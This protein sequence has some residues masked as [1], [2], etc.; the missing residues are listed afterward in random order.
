MGSDSSFNT[1]S[2]SELCGRVLL[3]DDD[4][5]MLTLL[6]RHLSHLN[7][8]NDKEE[9][10]VVDD[11]PLLVRINGRLLS[12]LGYK[13]TES[14]SSQE[15]LERVRSEPDRF[16]LLITDQT[17]PQL[18]GAE[19]AAEVLN[20]APNILVIMCTGHSNVVSKEKALAMGICRY[21]FKPV[22]GMELVEAVREVLDE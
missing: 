14:T 9:I 17:M 11:D 13:V 15:A 8:E 3:V 1:W 22:Q 21:V 7:C 12:D 19:L 18:T 16:D 4:S 5:S 6:Q 2:A 10:L 20:V